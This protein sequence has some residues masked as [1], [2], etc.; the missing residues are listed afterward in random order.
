MAKIY[1]TPLMMGGSGGANKDLPPLLDN[2]KAVAGEEENT[3]LVSADKMEESR[4]KELAGAVWVYGEH[5]PQNVNDGTKI[6]LTREECIISQETKSSLYSN[7][8]DK[9]LESLPSGSR[10]KL[11]K[12]KDTP[13]QWKLSRDTVTNELRLVLER[14]SV[15]LLGRKSYDAAEPSNPVTERRASGNNRYLYSNIHQWLNS[16]K[17]ANEWYTPSHTYDAPPTYQNEAGFLNQWSELEKSV[18]DTNDWKTI[19][20]TIDGGGEDIVR[21]KVA[22]LSIGEIGGDGVKDGNRLDIFNSDSDRAV[23]SDCWTRSAVASNPSA[24]WYVNPT[25]AMGSTDIKCSGSYSVRTVCAPNKYTMISGNVDSDGCYVV[26]RI[27][28]KV[29]KQVSWEST[30]DFFARQFTYNSKKQ[31]QT[32]L[33]GA[34][35]TLNDV[36]EGQPITELESGSKVKLGVWND[37]PLQWKVARD[38]VTNELRAFLEP[39]S[40]EQIGLMMWDNK[41]PS[42]TDSSRKTYGNNRYIY[43]NIHQWL[44][45]T[46]VSGWYTAQHS[47]DVAPD[48]ESSPGFLSG[49]SETDLEAMDSATWTVARA[50]VDGGGIETYIANI[51]LASSTELG[52]ESN[53]EGNKIDIF[54]ENA[55]R[56]MN[57][58]YWMRT[59]YPVGSVYARN[60]NLD[61]TLDPTQSGVVYTSMVR[62]LCALKSTTYVSLQPDSDGCY[63]ITGVNE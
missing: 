14:T 42:N 1:G 34:I 45:A 46:K 15:T 13:L 41:E 20:A 37:T 31:Y 61:G 49:W 40:A 58:Y 19:N 10:I 6:Q 25:G 7:A 33:E 32:M 60:V 43:S 21:A 12:L 57:K 17:D 4:A 23:G 24:A 11:G 16:D 3:I 26:T 47:A 8:V 62:P 27:S 44:N 38:T 53:G 52:L 59:I 36:P 50:P 5:V 54:N 2:F 28:G 48:Y 9:P 29:E 35:A 39:T 63:T 22:V 18:L 30:K 55:D 51:S 56:A